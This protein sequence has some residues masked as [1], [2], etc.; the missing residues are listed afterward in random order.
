MKWISRADFSLFSF[1]VYEFK[2]QALSATGQV[3]PISAGV[4][5]TPGQLSEIR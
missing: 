3:G 5:A 1:A 2:V 4:R